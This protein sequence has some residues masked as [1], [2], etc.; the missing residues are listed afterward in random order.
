MDTYEGEKYY[1]TKETLMET[2]EKYGVAI[3]PS[4]LSEDE[5]LK[6]QEG[7]WSTLEHISKNFTEGPIKQENPESWR[8]F[9]S[10]FPLHSMLL[11]HWALGHSQ[12]I[13]DL[14]Q[15][16]SILDIWK[17]FWDEED[18][19]TSFDGLSIH[20]P[21]EKTSRGWYSNNK[22]GWLHT[23][24]SY[25][26]N[27][28]ECLQS[29]VTAYDVN[30]G[31]AS[32]AFLESSHLY[33]KEFAQKFNKSSKAN[34]SKLE[35]DAEYD[36]YTKDCNCPKKVIQCPKGSIVFWDSRTIHCGQEASKKRASPNFRCVVYL[37][38]VPKR[39]ATAKTL[40]KKKKYFEEMRMT[41]HWPHKVKVF[42]KLPR[43]YGNKIPEINPLPK[44]VLTETGRKLVGY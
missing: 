21:P 29:W 10:L 17:T 31:D 26:R 9:Y 24:Q 13:W 20:L 22:I 6:M 12:F 15:K 38:Y 44:P 42:N 25:T 39:Y 11:Q 40:E 36:F 8:Q 14:R 43:T 27:S 41:S 1:C 37:C 7:M 23:D 35:S 30:P 34:W 16:E 3:I 33:H 2:V 18:L 4:V 19:I 5:C 32:L 28:F